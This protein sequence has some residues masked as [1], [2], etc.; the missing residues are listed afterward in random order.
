[1]ERERRA[2]AVE[3]RR[4]RAERLSAVT[5]PLAS[6]TAV[7]RRRRVGSA[8]LRQRG[9]QNGALLAVLLPAHTALWL[10]QPSWAWRWSALAL[11]VLLW[12]VLTVLLFD[13]RPTR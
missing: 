8:L 12:P 10:L 6:V 3:R 5:A 7:M 2:R 9:R 1:M 4:R 11:T 13:R